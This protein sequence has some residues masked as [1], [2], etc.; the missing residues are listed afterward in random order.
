M[1][2]HSNTTEGAIDLESD[3]Q[4]HKSRMT[5]R[6]VFIDFNTI[7]DV[8]IDTDENNNNYNNDDFMSTGEIGSAKH[9]RL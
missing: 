5:N 4:H 9:R 8:S 1:E 3:R 7:N 6:N 2:Q